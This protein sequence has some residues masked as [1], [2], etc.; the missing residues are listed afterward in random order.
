V[1]LPTF[2]VILFLINGT[3]YTHAEIAPSMEQCVQLL[4]QV[5][6]VLKT[7]V[8]EPID[9]YSASCLKILYFPQRDA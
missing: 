2:I 6:E 1:D 8:R 7:V 4:P 3:A 5:P 9:F